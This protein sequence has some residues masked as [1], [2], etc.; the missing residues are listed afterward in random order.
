M[1]RLLAFPALTPDQRQVLHEITDLAAEFGLPPE[2]TRKVRRCYLE[3]IGAG[4]STAVAVA[5][6]RRIV[7]GRTAAPSAG[8]TGPEAA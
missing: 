7:H 2:R 4:R 6:A 5:Q 3:E 8:R 1:A